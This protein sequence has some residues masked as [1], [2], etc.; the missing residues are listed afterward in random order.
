MDVETTF[1]SLKIKTKFQQAPTVIK[2]AF[3]ACQMDVKKNLHATT[4]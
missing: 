3:Y 2:S 1:P 4:N